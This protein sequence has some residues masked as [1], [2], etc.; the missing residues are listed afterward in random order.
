M[1]DPESLRLAYIFAVD[2]LAFL[3]VYLIVNLTLELEYGKAG[4]PNFGKVLSVAGGAFVAGAVPGRVLAA[5][6]NMFAGANAIT[7]PV[8]AECVRGLAPQ[9]PAILT[10][11]D[12][13]EDNVV[14]ATC[15]QSGVLSQD[16]LLSIGVLVMTLL[17]AASVGA[18]LGLVASY[19]ALRLRE[20]YLAMTLLAFGEFLTAVGYY[21]REIIGGTLGIQVIDPFSWA[22]AGMRFTVATLAIVLVA[23]L[24]ALYVRGVGRSPFGRVLR[25]M[26][27]QELAAEVLGKDTV[28]YK[29]TLLMISSA[30]SAVAGALW[31]FYS[32]GI[33]A[34]AFDRVTWTFLP[35]VMV[36]LGGAGNY[37]GVAL[38]TGVYWSARKLIDQYKMALEPVL[39]FSVIWFDR[40][41]FGVLL[42]VLL[43][44]RPKGLIPERP[45]Y[46]LK[47]STIRR[48]IESVKAK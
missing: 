39:P 29:R 33:I 48:I 12:Y 45:T 32:G 46:A 13:I 16:P 42:I 10:R 28:Y 18:V 34:T 15:L 2:L 40:L 4:I 1:I 11:M 19:P 41:A 23:V 31:A 43:I 36:I 3:G 21:N 26:R 24:V 17:L 47:K 6:Y 14:I 37:L 9:K 20:D 27:D 22:G 30:I 8:V 44:V 7:H 5:A 35:W 38:G 25:A